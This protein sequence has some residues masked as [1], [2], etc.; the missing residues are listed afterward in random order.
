MTDRHIMKYTQNERDQDNSTSALLV[1][2]ESSKQQQSW[3]LK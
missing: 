3:H 2:F 1:A